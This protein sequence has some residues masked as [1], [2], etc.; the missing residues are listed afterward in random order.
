[1]QFRH[2]RTIEQA[3]ESSDFKMERVC[4]MAWSPSQLRLAVVTTR[5]RVILYDEKGSAREKFNTR[6]TV[7]PCHFPCDT[8]LFLR[9]TRSF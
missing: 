7:P 8:R 3:T 5:R 6:N 9:I 4:A 1:M 2:L